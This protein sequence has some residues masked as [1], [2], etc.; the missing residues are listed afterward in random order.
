[1]AVRHFQRQRRIANDHAIA[2]HQLS[3][4]VVPLGCRSMG[5]K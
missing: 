3:M 5:F 1:M 4:S 2:R